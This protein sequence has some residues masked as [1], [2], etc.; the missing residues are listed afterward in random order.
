MNQLAQT[1]IS[2]QVLIQ[3]EVLRMFFLNLN[4]LWGDWLHRAKLLNEKKMPDVKRMSPK[5]PKQKPLH[6]VPVI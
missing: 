1:M 2:D 6:S 5:L 3:T 4:Y